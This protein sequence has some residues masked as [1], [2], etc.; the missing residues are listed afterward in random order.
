M[1]DVVR[2]IK[3]LEEAVSG[4]SS[5]SKN[6]LINDAIKCLKTGIPIE[7]E[8]YVNNEEEKTHVQDKQI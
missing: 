1:I 5:K 4:E 8:K 3:I 2:V 7:K 6:S